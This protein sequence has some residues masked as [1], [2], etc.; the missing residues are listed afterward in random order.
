MKKVLI[1]TILLSCVLLINGNVVSASSNKNKTV[2]T[3]SEYTY[4]NGE[5]KKI[6]I[7]EEDAKNKVKF[8]KDFKKLQKELEKDEKLDENNNLIPE[9]SI[10]QVPYF[11]IDDGGGGGGVSSYSITVE[12]EDMVVVPCTLSTYTLCKGI[13]EK[14]GSI[15]QHQMTVDFNPQN[16]N[17]GEVTNTLT[18]YEPPY[19]SFTDYMAVFVDSDLTVKYETIEANAYVD[20][21]AQSWVYWCGGN[22]SYQYENLI[23]EEDFNYSSSDIYAPNAGEDGAI[24]W[25]IYDVYADDDRDVVEPGL[26]PH[27]P[28][29]DGCAIPELQINEIVYTM[30]FD[31]K[32]HD[33]NDFNDR[34]D[35]S[36][37]SE[38]AH[39]YARI[40]FRKIGVSWFVNLDLMNLTINI[41]ESYGYDY[42]S[43]RR[44]DM[45]FDF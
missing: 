13:V 39:K 11:M 37:S 44:I 26:R 32:T 1:F 31:F 9:L 12:G 2:T 10:A 27:L 19:H 17:Y 16:D 30:T 35:L 3:Y 40:D 22:E 20:Y 25:T 15:T 33:G 24:L 23:Y 42:D 45:R 14:V 7:T 4:E 36:F 34:G 28:V 18:W 8:L 6:K 21:D 38:Y 5:A 43:K 29:P 41:V